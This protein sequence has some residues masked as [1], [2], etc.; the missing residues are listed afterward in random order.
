MR[1]GL[2][3][4]LA[5]SIAM[6]AAAYA[7]PAPRAPAAPDPALEAAQQ[8]YEA[9]PETDRRAIQE[10]LMWTGDYNGVVGV[11]F[12]KR[13]FD[14]IRAYQK[15]RN[16]P[17]TGV[18]SDRDW[19]ALTADAKRARESVR[20][21]TLD[22]SRTGI[23][24]G[25]P[26][27]VTERT[28][29]TPKSSPIQSTAYQSGDGVL[30]L[31]TVG[32]PLSAL[33]LDQAFAKELAPK[34]GRKVTYKFQR[35]DFF[36]TSGEEAGRIF[37]TRAAK[38]EK[39][40]RGFTFSFPAA[41][42]ADFERVM[43]AVA[44]SF[45]PFPSSLTAAA[46]PAASGPATAA[47]KPAFAATGLVIAPGR[48]L[49]S[50]G[51]TQACANPVIN[52]AAARAAG[53]DPASGAVILSIQGGRAAQIGAARA[54]AADGES[55]GAA[56]LRDA[57]RRR[58]R[59]PAG[60]RPRRRRDGSAGAQPPGTAHRTRRGQSEVDSGGVARGRAGDQS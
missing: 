33:D 53:G 6:A 16:S 32:A 26:M 18:L 19:A 48:V 7:Q 57:A 28:T 50:A 60:G 31:D 12:G 40:L 24:L 3:C 46:T 13:A 56:R 34:P 20:F 55:A 22:D 49:T 37:Y 2:L 4:G 42:R 29:G 14:G 27:R 17:Q 9:L 43:L 11:N 5:L 38:N 25:A 21:A 8:A 52:G 44:N 30:R 36:V 1:H 41:R 47:A 39:E 45:D 10:A 35:P 23:R 59:G 54:P 15:K 51:V 58:K